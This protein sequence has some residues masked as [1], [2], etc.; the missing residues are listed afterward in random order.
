MKTFF[1]TFA[2]FIFFGIYLVGIFIGISHNKIND[3]KEI[4]KPDY[5]FYYDE[6]YVNC[7]LISDI[8]MYCVF[9]DI[10]EI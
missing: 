2:V 1:S 7:K 8:E 9:K 10:R 4:I 3:E 5:I 6:D